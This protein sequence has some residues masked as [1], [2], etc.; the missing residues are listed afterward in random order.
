VA[1]RSSP[2]AIDKKL[3]GLDKKK[4]LPWDPA[5]IL[6]GEQ[7][8]CF[9][10]KRR[11]KAFQATRQV[12]KTFL[13]CVAFIDA[14]LN[15]PESQALYV[16]LSAVHSTRVLTPTFRRLLKKYQIPAKLVDDDLVFDN[17]SVVYSIGLGS[18]DRTKALQG[19]N[20]VVL[21]IFDETQDLESTIDEALAIVAPT[22]ATYQ[23][24]ILC[25]GIPG[26]VHG[27]GSWWEITHG[28]KSEGWDQFRASLL[29][30]IHLPDPQ[31]EY[32]QAA[33]DLGE[34]NPLFI[35]HYR[36]EWPS[37]DQEARVYRWDPEVNIYVGPPPPCQHYGSG[38]DPA[39]VRDCE[40]TVLL[41]WNDNDPRIWVVAES[42]S[43]KGGGGDYCATADV[44]RELSKR[45]P[46]GRSFY[47][48]GSAAKGLLATTMSRDFSMYLEPVP[49][50]N[51]DFE[52]PRVNALF[53][54]R[55]LMVNKDVTPELAKDLALTLWDLKARAAGRNAYSRL[56][57]HPDVGDALRAAIWNVPGFDRPAAEAPRKPTEAEA[58]RARL[59]AAFKPKKT[60][61][62]YA[63]ILPTRTIGLPTRNPFERR[64]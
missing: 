7:L 17:G 34:D 35:R 57:P 11:R 45:F 53:Q 28:E 61:D 59:D 3:A 60:S 1:G 25:L 30:N 14:C 29:Q 13:A 36:N 54:K 26:R 38:T 62:R 4:R 42:V 31:A 32:D 27:L 23:G 10:S 18:E 6:Y 49:P 33:K 55:R 43:P 51:L 20:K 15:T 8:R 24:T 2:A 56:G 16:D 48:F 22:L 9:Q 64:R 19:Y 12:G 63:G 47:D 41:G 21:V 58:E 44:L 46:I 52:I 39:G 40:A 50:K 5:A 37:H